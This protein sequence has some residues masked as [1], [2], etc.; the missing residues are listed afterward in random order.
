M[1]PRLERLLAT[2]VAL[3]MLWLL[4]PG[5]PR[6]SNAR[7][8]ASPVADTLRWPHRAIVGAP[9]AIR[10]EAPR[11]SSL[12]T[13]TAP[14]GRADSSRASGTFT[15]EATA[16]A[17]GHWRWVLR[18]GARSDTIGVDVRERPALRVLIVEARPSFETTALARRLAAQGASVTVRTRL[19]ARDERTATWGPDAPPTAM[20]AAALDRLDAVVFGPGATTLL[21]DGE[22]T[23]THDAV[24]RGLGV[25][26]LVDSTATRGLLFPFAAASRG[27]E[28]EAVHPVLEGRRLASPVRAAPLTLSGGMPLTLGDGGAALSVIAR[29]GRGALAATRVLTPS[30]WTLAG[31]D[32]LAAAWWASQLGAVL[33]AARAEWR[34]AD[35][36]RPTVDE[37]LVV[38]RVGDAMPF[39][40][41]HEADGTVD[42]VPLVPV[43]GD[44]L[45]RRAALWPTAPG[46]LA[47]AAGDDTLHLLVRHPAERGAPDAPAPAP[48]RWWAWAVL[49]AACGVLWRRR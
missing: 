33:R 19:T 22:R 28:P 17:A 42:S 13:L 3:A 49:L 9:I 7:D 15:I 32:S 44:S 20:T 2:L 45:R 37:R 30:R 23:A 31:D 18:R 4:R 1:T 27:L 12:V 43:P 26:H 47:L 41:L 46:W 48:V 11:D 16:R 29:D 39:A 38:E 14:D 8:L 25:L 36:L 10:G 21:G 40:R 24:R 35:T 5:A 34:V 6:W